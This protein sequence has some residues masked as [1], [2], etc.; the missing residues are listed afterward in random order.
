MCLDIFDLD[1]IR[2]EFPAL[3]ETDAQGRPYIY[4]DGPGGTQ[5]PAGV[6]QAMADYFRTANANQGGRFATSRRNDET[7]DK[8]RQCMAD[9][10]NAPLGRRDCVWSEYDIAYLQFEQGHRPLSPAGGRDSG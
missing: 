6:P 2:S 9:F 4:F 7:I 8:A 3:G 5:V 10:L 1:K